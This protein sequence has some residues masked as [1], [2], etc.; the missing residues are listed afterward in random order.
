MTIAMTPVLMDVDTGVDDAIA[1]AAAV[2]APDADLVALSTVAGNVDV[3]KTTAN[4]LAVLDWLGVEGVPVHLGASRP[5]CR[6]LDDA[7]HFHGR[8]GLGDSALLPSGRSLGQD[9]G[10]AAII[11]QVMAR[12][13]ELTLVCVGPLTNLAIALNVAPELPSLLRAVVIMGGAFFRAGNVTPHAE[14]NIYADPE[15]AGHVFA[16]PFAELTVV[17]LDVTERVSI[18]AAAWAGMEDA[19][20][21][22]ARLI[23][24]VCRRSFEERRDEAFYLHDPLA[25]AVAADASLVETEQFAVDVMTGDDERGRTVARPGGTVRVA[26][27]VDVARFTAWFQAALE[28]S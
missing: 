25:L 22:G 11:R 14:F 26:R 2:G 13:G 5:L 4:T 21:R 10:P 20:A 12:P 17:G 23:H 6:P 24:R 19:D 28:R 27:D 16:A 1:I 7:A 15:A 8:D 9:R 3:E 18:S